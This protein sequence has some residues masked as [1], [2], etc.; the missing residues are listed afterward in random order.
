M[1]E[2]SK[3]VKVV[4]LINALF[5]F[6]YAFFFLIIPEIYLELSDTPDILFSPVTWRQLGAAFLALGIFFVLAV[7]RAD[8]EKV[9]LFWE[10]GIFF[11]ISILIIGIWAA[12]A[13]PGSADYQET[14]RIDV[15]IPFMLSVL[16]IYF[17]YRIN[18][19]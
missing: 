9:K 12:I 16:N 4:F 3:E 13:F 1:T 17:Y 7:K 2:V 5:A 10:F 8:W 18:W 14:D 19:F 6:L 11:L 15:L